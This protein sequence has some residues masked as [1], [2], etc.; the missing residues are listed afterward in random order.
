MSNQ[1]GVGTGISR[2][3]F[4]KRAAGVGGLAAFPLLA[5]CGSGEQGSAASDTVSCS[6]EAP[7]NA[8]ELTLLAYRFPP[9]EAHA[10]QMSTCATSTEN[11]NVSTRLLPFDE[12]LR[13][14]NTTMSTGSN[15]PYQM[16]YAYDRTLI[17]YASKDWLVP[18]DNFIEE[19]RDEYNLGD[20]PADL[21]DRGNFEGATYGFPWGQNIHIFFYRRDIFE[22]QDLSPPETIDQWI[23]ACEKLAKTQATPNPMALTYDQSSGLYTIFHNLLSAY[24]GQWFDE[25]D[26]PAFNGDEG[27]RAVETM[28]KLFEFLPEG[29]LSATDDDVMVL[30]QQGQVAMGNVWVS[31]AREV[32]DPEVSAQADNIAFAPAP[33]G[34]ES[35]VPA[36]NWAQDFY[37]LPAN[38]GVEPDLTFRLLGESLNEK[39]MRKTAG[40]TIPSRDAVL[41]ADEVRSEYPWLDVATETI[42]AGAKGLPR[43]P[44][45]GVAL[46]LVGNSLSQV[47]GGDA[48]PQQALDKAAREMESELEQS[49]VL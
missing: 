35:G 28:Q 25:N 45:M 44:F 14:A 16:A 4:L 2:R 19:Y 7:N 3:T 18:L 17:E 37:V 31:R 49:G 1:T 12:M 32:T 34:S 8:T 30:L 46:E 42:N 22:Q 9:I 21:W 47:L 5:G 40:L 20:I 39:S 26:V 48:Q 27:V 6:L 23:A 15:V 11:L 24:G 38:S 29:A 10:D 41:E 33:K 13:Q 36:A 43:K